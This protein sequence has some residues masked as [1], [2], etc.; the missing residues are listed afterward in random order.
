M[1]HLPELKKAEGKWSACNNGDC[2]C[3]QIWDTEG[4]YPVARVER[5][6]WGDDYPTLKIDGTSL[7][8]KVTAVM[9][10][11]TYG[12]VSPELAKKNAL[13]IAAAPDL[14]GALQNLLPRFEKAA[15]HAG[16]DDETISCATEMHR[17]AI[18]KAGF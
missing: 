18:K 6:K 8:R 9:E 3:G 10:Q 5:G 4:D 12:E 11:I 2:S 7:D 13:L 1:K 16:N 17:A 14:L 15:R